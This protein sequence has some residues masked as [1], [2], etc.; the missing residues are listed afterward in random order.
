MSNNDLLD[1]VLGEGDGTGEADEQE[2]RSDDAVI[3]QENELLGPLIPV[4]DFIA[5]EDIQ[6]FVRAVL[7]ATPVVFWVQP[8]N[9]EAS[10]C[11]PDEMLEGG[12]VLRTERFARAAFYVAFAHDHDAHEKDLLLAAAILHAVTRY[13]PTGN[14]VYQD[15]M[16]L[17]TVDNFVEAVRAN[18]EEELEALANGEIEDTDLL[19]RSSPLEIE[20]EDKQA[21]LRLIHCHRGTG[22]TIPEAAPVTT[23]EWNIHVAFMVACNMHHIVDGDHIVEKRWLDH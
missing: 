17:Y 23:L 7:L 1:T 13:I 12:Q 19:S 11:P 15:P 14:D 10:S 5:D 4:I 9:T 6:S 8:A 22:A 2:Y 18:R 21:I 20:E 3:N 16:Y